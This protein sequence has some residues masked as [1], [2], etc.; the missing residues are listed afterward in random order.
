MTT[1]NDT[2]LR[3]LPFGMLLIAPDGRILW[4]NDALCHMLRQPADRLTDRNVSALPTELQRLLETDP[5]LFTVDEGQHWVS[6]ET[7]RDEQG[8]RLL[9]LTD[10]SHE[11]Q[12]AAEN[13]R[14]RQQVEDLKLTDDLTGLPNKRAI[15]QSLDLHISRSRRYQNPLS[16]VL[17][18]ADVTAS[19]SVEPLSREPSLLS[20]SRFLRD[21][22]RWVD[23]IARWD[24]RV[25]L[26][27]LPETT[28]EDA[29]ALLEK[30][31]TEQQSL[32]LPQLPAEARPILRFGLAC[33]Q[34]G[35]DQR[36]LLRS[37]FNALQRDLDA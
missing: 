4:V 2:L 13:A 23:Q 31:A 24:D 7:F 29:R 21:R 32:L 25:F 22:V 14:L 10:V 15:S 17:V 8:Q 33:W 16:V 26:L 30:I 5:R 35:D 3:H 36:T 34:K 9:V 6:R 20:V 27:V 1:I 18:Y 12:L 37:A 11:E 28:E 19:D